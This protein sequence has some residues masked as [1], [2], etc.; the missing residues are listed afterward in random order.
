MKK[1]I[2]LIMILSF[3]FLQDIYAKSNVIAKVK[4][5][6]GKAYF[7]P[8]S[9]KKFKKLKINQKIK[10]D[11]IIKT[12]AGARVSLVLKGGSIIELKGNS[13]ITLNKKLLNKSSASLTSGRA[14]FQIKKILKQ[15]GSF[16]VFTPTAVVGVRGTEYEI[17][18]ADDGSL[19]ANV[20]EGEIAVNNEKEEVT[21]KKNQSVEAPVDDPKLSKEDKIKDADEWN[22]NKNKELNENPAE[23]MN[24]VSDNLKQTLDNQKKVLKDLSDIKPDDKEKVSDN[25]D[26]GLFN[27]CKSEGLVIAARK[28]KKKNPA[29]SS[30]QNSYK[31]IKS[32][33][34]KLDKLNKLLD[35]KFAKLD[36]IYNTKSKELDKKFDDINKNLDEKF[37]K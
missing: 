16:N 22:N 35:E 1:I 33:Y 7:S 30:I 23:K 3:C 17:A 12:S 10:E 19:L 15:R 25:I 27:Q 5:I 4:L 11:T 36:E 28:I 14:K 18:I 32:I 20:D 29:N 24:A 34:D 6:K 13:R 2:T 21:V 9:P 37:N 31:T 26:S 8:K